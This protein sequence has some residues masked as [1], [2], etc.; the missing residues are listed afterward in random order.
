MI[1]RIVALNRGNREE[2]VG[3]VHSSNSCNSSA[4]QRVPCRPRCRDRRPGNLTKTAGW[5]GVAEN[6]TRRNSWRISDKTRGSTRRKSVLKPRARATNS[7]GF[8][9]GQE[10]FA[11]LGHARH[12]HDANWNS[13]FS[14]RY[15]SSLPICGLSAMEV[16]S[17]EPPGRVREWERERERGTR[18]PIP[19]PVHARPFTLLSDDR[20]FIS[21]LLRRHTE[22]PSASFPSLCPPCASF[23]FALINDPGRPS[24]LLLAFEKNLHARMLRWTPN[25]EIGWYFCL[26]FFIITILDTHD[27]CRSCIFVYYIY[28]KNE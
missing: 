28:V 10:F 12:V 3:L 5:L 23:H 13:C 18:S 21:R 1:G 17:I 27:W 14:Y 4:R 15:L 6:G 19:A 25:Q 2:R 20:I 16:I 8:V 9:R 7:G 26:L 24:A 22:P 11:T